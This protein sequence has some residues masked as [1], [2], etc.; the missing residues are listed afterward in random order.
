LPE[1]SLCVV[2]GAMGSSCQCNGLRRSG[3]RELEFRRE[4]R[5]SRSQS[6]S[7]KHLEL[8]VLQK[9]RA[10]AGGDESCER[11]ARSGTSLSFLITTPGIVKLSSRK[12]SSGSV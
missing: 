7:S 9:S 4:Q 2:P 6:D 1:L 5:V 8:G 3:L 11:T 12:L 10:G